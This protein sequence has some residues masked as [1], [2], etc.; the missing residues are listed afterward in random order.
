MTMNEGGDALPSTDRRHADGQ[1]MNFR[2]ILNEL[3]KLKFEIEK[4]T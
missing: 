1:T 2:K 3:L 4:D